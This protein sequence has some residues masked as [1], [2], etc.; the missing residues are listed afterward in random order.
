MN[1]KNIHCKWLQV[2]NLMKSF[3]CS[4]CHYLLQKNKYYDNVLSKFSCLFLSKKQLFVY[5]W[6]MMTFVIIHG[7]IFCEQILPLVNSF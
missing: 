6:K 7:G 5:Y 1:E 3:N 4:I 2:F